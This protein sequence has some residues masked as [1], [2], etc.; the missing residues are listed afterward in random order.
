MIRISSLC[1]GQRRSVSI[2]VN[3]SHA[4]NLF[5]AFDAF[6]DCVEAVLRQQPAIRI[7]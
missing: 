2:D 6:E 5:E 4:A 7:R 3:S 1:G